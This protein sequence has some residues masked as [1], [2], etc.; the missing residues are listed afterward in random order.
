[1]LIRSAVLQDS[2][3]IARIQVDSYRVAYA[4]ILPAEYLEHFTIP[5][6]E[7]DWQDWFVANTHEILL[8]AEDSAGKLSGYALGKRNLDDVPPY[9]GELVA[10]HV[11]LNTQRQGVGQLLISAIAL[12]LQTQGCN[13]L[14]LWVLDANPARLFYEKLGGRYIS[15]KPWDNNREFSVNVS[16]VAYGWLDILELIRNSQPGRSIT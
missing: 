10:L 13:S 15:S 5:E 11:R 16:E 14:F 2:P 12:A 6:Q 8:V 3:A 7:Q 4:P 9:E 1:M